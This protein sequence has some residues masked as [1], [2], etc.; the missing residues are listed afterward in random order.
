MHKFL[1]YMNTG[2]G[3]RC[4]R[5]SFT[6]ISEKLNKNFC[7]P[8]LG[9]L[10]KTSFCLLPALFSCRKADISVKQT[11]NDTTLDLELRSTSPAE[12][13]DI[14]TFNDDRLMHLDSYQRIEGYTTGNIDV[15][16][17]NGDKIIFAYAN[18]GRDTY[19]WINI[20][21]VD[22]LTAI[23]VA[24]ENENREHPVMSGWSKAAAGQ[25]KPCEICITPLRSEILLRS[26]RC[27]FCNPDKGKARIRNAKV[28][29]TNVNALC[30]ITSDV[31]T[32]PRQIVNAGEPDYKYLEGMKC[33]DI[34]LQKI[35]GS[36]GE[37]RYMT[38]ISL[39]CYPNSCEEEG[40][41][42]PFTRLVIEGDIDGQ[43]YW[44]PI[45]I[46]RGKDTAEP[47]IHRNRR[48]T[49]DIT[50]RRKGT[51][52]PEQLIEIEDADIFMEIDSWKEK[53]NYS[54]SF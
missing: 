35:P 21:S 51:S 40:P 33:P 2:K 18:S 47:G 39:L 19:D 49:F 11:A 43:T 28:Y 37:Q 14:F 34:L 7:K 24:L 17:Q 29:L 32:R 4:R 54:I 26:I 38:E 12:C 22:A 30:G 31:I 13:L 23:E 27:D 52:G 53:D 48:Y 3:N 44:W 45:N 6:P 8:V 16:S 9:T 20:N 25:K 1:T 5:K 41:G 36:I 50:I 42:T 10:I 46:N 15:R